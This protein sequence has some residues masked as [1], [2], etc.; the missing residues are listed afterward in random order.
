MP[1]GKGR[2]RKKGKERSTLVKKSATIPAS[3][4]YHESEDDEDSIPLN[5]HLPKGRGRSLGLVSSRRPGTSTSV[6]IMEE[7]E[8][9]AQV[10]ISDHEDPEEVSSDVDDKTKDPDF[11]DTLQKLTVPSPPPPSTP[12]S[13]QTSTTT[14]KSSQKSQKSSSQSQKSSSQSQKPQKTK[15]DYVKSELTTEQDDELLEFYKNNECLYN[16]NHKYGMNAKHKNF[17]KE[18]QAEKMGI[19]GKYIGQ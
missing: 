6:T 16:K 2:G 5:V 9:S 4:F 13:S 1:A 10:V 14:P 15:R 18:E 7:E 3:K 11:E 12:I 17:L 8:S 19:T